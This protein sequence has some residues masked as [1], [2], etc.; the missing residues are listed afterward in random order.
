MSERTIPANAWDIIEAVAV[1]TEVPISVFCRPP[2]QPRAHS[3]AAAA[4]RI[5]WRRLYDET[6]PDG[7]RRYSLRQIGLWTGS[8]HTTV[9]E[10]LGLR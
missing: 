1:E 4:R 5:A 9:A 10:G 8:H 6:W 7:A 3:E 2:T